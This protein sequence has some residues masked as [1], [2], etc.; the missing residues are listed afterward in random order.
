MGLDWWGWVVDGVEDVGRLDGVS[1]YLDGANEYLDGAQVH[2][3][4]A[5]SRV[6][7]C[8][9]YCRRYHVDVVDVVDGACSSDLLK[10]L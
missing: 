9:R 2:V 8:C 6:L 5:C 7:G 1:G 10:M 4:G 3:D